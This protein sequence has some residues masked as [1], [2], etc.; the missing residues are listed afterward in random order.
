[1]AN[2]EIADVLVARRPRKID[3]SG[4]W[5]AIRTWPI[6]PV[7]LLSLVLVSGV[8]APW[9][10]PH[11]PDRG[12]LQERNLP[13][14]W[15]GDETAFKTVAESV[16]LGE[17]GRFISLRNAQK[18]DPQAVVGDSLEVVIRPAG[19]TKYL[20]GT[21]QLGRDLLS[22]VIYGARISLIVAAVT[23]GVG[24]TIGVTLGLVAGWYGRWVDEL[25]MRFVDVMLSMPLILVALVLVVALGQSFTVIVT[26]LCLFIW[27]RFAR[28]VRGE[29]LQL[30][31]MDYVS[32][33]KVSG[34]S[35]PRILLVHIFP[36]TINT[37]IVV[38][39]LQVGIVI[40]LESVLSFLGAG[41]PP[42]T[43][44]WGSMVSDGRDR[45]AGFWWIATFPG[46]AIMLTVMSLNLF[47]DWLRDKLDPRLRQL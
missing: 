25:I 14:F 19:S 1:M 13:P 5:H 24:G 17:Q 43:A 11:D 3:L 21:D 26:V 31:H 4:A 42:P 18:I 23:L 27:P 30:K 47:G 29:V 15:S 46:L 41:V 22:R 28:Q 12:N 7:F 35:T 45:L 2:R 33:A 40:L 20:L 38:A 37:L 6:V 36:G 10:A 44:A 34:A 9:I 16:D 32:L 8:A 39:T